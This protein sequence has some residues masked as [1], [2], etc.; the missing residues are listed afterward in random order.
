MAISFLF[1]MINYNSWCGIWY[2]HK[3]LSPWK[4][5]SPSASKFWKLL[6]N[7]AANIVPFISLSVHRRCNLSFLWDPWCKG[8]ALADLFFSTALDKLKVNDVIVE[9][10]WE[11]PLFIPNVIRDEIL[12]INILGDQPVIFWEGSPTPSPKK[13]LSAF[14][15]HLDNVIWC[16]YVWHK[17]HALR[18]SCYS[19]M[20]F[21]RKLKTADNLIVRGIPVL[22]N[23]SFCGSFEENHSHLFFE[24]DFSF[25]ILSSLL[26]ITANF[27]LRP[28]MLQVFD[29]LDNV[30]NF[31]RLEKHF[32]FLLMAAMIY[33]IWRERNNRRFKHCWTSPNGIQG[34]II[35]AIRAKTRLWKDFEKLKVLFSWILG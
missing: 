24:C 11:L 21:K 27:Y 12:E 34:E 17:R 31:G 14:Y 16:K 28:N 8:K 9:N 13:V 15:G 33:F 23:C 35:N 25:S 4:P 7:V 20:A 10:R 19:W 1:R 22:S 29:Y 2:R 30:R 32:C 6:C 18:Y 3:Y 5:A 26:P